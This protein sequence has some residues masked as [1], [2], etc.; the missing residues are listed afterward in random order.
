MRTTTR[1]MRQGVLGEGVVARVSLT[2]LELGGPE[3]SSR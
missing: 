2:F 3:A 1:P